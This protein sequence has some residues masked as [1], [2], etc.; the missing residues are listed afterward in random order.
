MV[1]NRKVWQIKKLVSGTNAWSWI[2]KFDKTKGRRGAWKALWAYYSGLGETLNVEAIMRRDLNEL[3]YLG[4]EQA[5][6]FEKFTMKLQS[7]FNILDHE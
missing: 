4:N 1:D 2:E 6:S 7:C 3:K 5:F